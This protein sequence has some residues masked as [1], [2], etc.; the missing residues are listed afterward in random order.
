MYR[1]TKIISLVLLAIN[2]IGAIY[3]GLS[4]ILDPSGESIQFPDGTLDNSPFTNYLIPGIILL[5]VNGVLSILTFIL[6]IIKHKTGPGFLIT[7]GILLGGWICMQM[8]LLNMFFAPFHV[9]F[10]MIGI[11]FL[12]S[13]LYMR[14][15]HH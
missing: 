2:G 1:F 6:L 11:I 4:L 13:G 9:P 15:K 5:V 10:L 8:I 14:N 3:G 12:A 7:Q